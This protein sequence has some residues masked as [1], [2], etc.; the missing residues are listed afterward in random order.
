MAS[1]HYLS[2]IFRFFRWFA[3]S[4]ILGAPV[5]LPWIGS[6][7][8]VAETGMNGATQNF[9]TGLHEFQDMAFVL[10]FLR[11]T[12]DFVD[13]GAN[14]GSYTILA[15][16]VCGARTLSI[17]PIPSTFKHLRRNVR[18]NGIENLVSLECCGLADRPGR[19][20][21]IADAG[22]MN[23]V[24]PNHYSGET[25]E[26]PVRALD[27]IIGE[28]RPVLLKIDV[29]GFEENVLKGAQN[30]VD[31]GGLKAILVEGDSSNIR[32]H[33]LSSGFLRCAYDPFKR[34]LGTTTGT[35][36][37]SYGNHLWVR[38]LKWVDSR[39]EEAP[40]FNLFDEKI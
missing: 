38:D 36:V 23:R 22:V 32:A 3:G 20:R 37:P 39:L 30:V 29:E 14:I 19:L 4:R 24:A 40:C 12:D 26:V 17:E 10:H 33:L 25:M 7:C 5:I 1:R 8:L 13:V 35:D 6:S 21:F 11:K 18:V 15:S 16:K 31:E 28:F 9:Y 27:D 34:N 2:V